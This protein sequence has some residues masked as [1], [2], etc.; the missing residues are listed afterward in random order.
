MADV[1]GRVLLPRDRYQDPSRP[2]PL[3]R[4]ATAAGHWRD[5]PNPR[6]AHPTELPPAAAGGTLRDRIV[7]WWE[8]DESMA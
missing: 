4:Q 3:N 2:E 6:R 1:A 5:T 7:A 8:G